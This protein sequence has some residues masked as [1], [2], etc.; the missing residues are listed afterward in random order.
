MLVPRVGCQTSNRTSFL[1]MTYTC[2]ILAVFLFGKMSFSMIGIVLS[3]LT[4]LQPYLPAK[5]CIKSQCLLMNGSTPQLVLL[6]GLG[7]LPLQVGSHPYSTE[8]PIHSYPTQPF[9]GE[10]MTLGSTI[11]QTSQTLIYS[12]SSMIIKPHQR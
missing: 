3:V 10:L 1:H 5:P 6:W 4:Q 12:S 7:L 8:P 11:T 9:N 2:F